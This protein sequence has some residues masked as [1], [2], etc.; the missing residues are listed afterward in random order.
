MKDWYLNDWRI[1]RLLL[2]LAIVATFIVTVS[3]AQ[4]IRARLA[5]HH[6]QARQNVTSGQLVAP[7]MQVS[8]RDPGPGPSPRREPANDGQ[9]RAA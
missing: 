1:L 8:P 9:P 3:L 5:A 6:G 2:V 4:W 7:G